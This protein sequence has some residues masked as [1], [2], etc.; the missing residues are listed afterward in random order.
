MEIVVQREPS[1]ALTT[2]GT[3]EVS[4]GTLSLF[5]FTLE[6]QVRAAGVKVYGET[7]IPANR[8]PLAV[9]RSAKFN[10]YLPII[11]GVP[12]Y[13]GVRIHSL[14]N[15]KQTLGCIGVGQTSA[16]T[17]GDL[18]EDVIQRSHAA[19]DA[20]MEKIA[21]RDGKDPDGV[22]RWVIKEPTWITIRNAP[23]VTA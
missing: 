2:M 14:N 17:N 15:R 18:A 4:D 5:L 21:Q 12:G 19:M 22:E 10:K 16:D 20:L 9:T 6:D 13:E 7:A 3:M 11:G 8:Y 23:G 1:R